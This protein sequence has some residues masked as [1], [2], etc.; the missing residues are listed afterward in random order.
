MNGIRNDNRPDSR[1][2]LRRPDTNCAKPA[3]PPTTPPPTTLSQPD[4]NQRAEITTRLGRETSGVRDAPPPPAADGALDYNALCHDQPA[5]PP[6][7]PPAT[8]TPVAPLATSTEPPM[9]SCPRGAAEAGA[10]TPAE[11]ENLTR[12]QNAVVDAGV[13]LFAASN[14][15]TIAQLA[16]RLP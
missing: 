3:T 6:A 13:A 11:M 12:T 15:M 10:P 7:A 8:E 9:T 2:D 14:G 16:E 4:P 1:T 5:A